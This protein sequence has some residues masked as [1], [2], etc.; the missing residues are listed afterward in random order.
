[1]PQG[2][3]V[4]TVSSFLIQRLLGYGIQQRLSFYNHF[5]DKLV[6][7]WGAERKDNLTRLQDAKL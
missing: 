1:M 5:S 6:C 2:S 3:L 7:G 4:Q